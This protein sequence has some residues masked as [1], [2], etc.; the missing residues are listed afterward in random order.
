MVSKIVAMN[1]RGVYMGTDLDG[2]YCVFSSDSYADNLQIGDRVRGAFHSD[3]SAS[4]GKNL[5]RD[6]EVFLYYESWGCGQR[7][8]FELLACLNRPTHIYT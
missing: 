7:Q 5:S 2:D 6:V 4:W 3:G 1:D 8:A